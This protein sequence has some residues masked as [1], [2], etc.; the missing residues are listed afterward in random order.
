MLILLVAVD[1]PKTAPVG[2][3]AIAVGLVSSQLGL[4]FCYGYPQSPITI[5]RACEAAIA[6][7]SIL[8]ILRMPLR[9]PNLPTLG[10]SPV[11][12]QPHHLL[13]SPE[14]NLTLWQFM[15]VSWMTPLISVGSKRQLDDEDVWQLSFEFQHQIL[16]QKFRELG[17]SVVRR[18]LKA[19]GLDLVILS[20]LAVIEALSST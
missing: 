16:H 10:I 2:S 13:R 12:E 6:L 17:G 14:D 15:T 1:R 5:L 4:L 19:N 3:L 20:C 18:L 7:L 9:D 8:C 11:F